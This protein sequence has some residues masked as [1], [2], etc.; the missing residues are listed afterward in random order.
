MVAMHLAHLEEESTE[1][2]EEDKTK[3][4]DGISG[5]TEEFFVH[6]AWA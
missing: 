6:L 4:P 3:D 1:R 5:V 2:K